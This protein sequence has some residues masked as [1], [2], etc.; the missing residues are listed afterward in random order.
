MGSLS[1]GGRAI[2]PPT[3]RSFP[4]Q[5]LRTHAKN[6]LRTAPL[7][8]APEPVYEGGARSPPK[9]TNPYIVVSISQKRHFEQQKCKGFLHRVC[10]AFFGR[11]YRKKRRETGFLAIFRPETPVRAAPGQ[12]KGAAGMICRRRHSQ[13]AQW[14]GLE[15]P[16]VRQS[17]FVSPGF[18]G[19]AGSLRPWAQTFLKHPAKKIGVSRAFPTHD[20]RCRRCPACRGRRRRRGGSIRGAGAGEARKGAARRPTG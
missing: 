20:S 4:G 11:V 2:R 10:E 16:Q 8:P 7:Q 17:E 13:K 6:T 14:G 9:P 5:G 12:K 18:A 19:R 3:A 1:G 15:D